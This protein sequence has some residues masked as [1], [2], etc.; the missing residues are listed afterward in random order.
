MLTEVINPMLQ[1]TTQSLSA[2]S[3]NLAT[4][5]QSSGKTYHTNKIIILNSHTFDMT[6]CTYTALTPFSVLFALSIIVSVLGT[7]IAIFIIDKHNVYVMIYI[8]YWCYLFGMIVMSIICIFM[9]NEIKELMAFHTYKNINITY[10]NDS[11]DIINEN[12]KMSK[13]KLWYPTYD[14]RQ[15]VRVNNDIV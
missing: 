2:L 1:A 6:Y 12:K 9:H 10:H 7:T 14:N 15:Y 8:G 11:N 13:I 5:N 3:R 4:G